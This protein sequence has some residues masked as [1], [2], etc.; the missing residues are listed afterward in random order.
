MFAGFYR[1]LGMRHFV[2]RTLPRNTVLLDDGLSTL[3]V[4]RVRRGDWSLTD[5]FP[6]S[7][8]RRLLKRVLN[9][10]DQE[11]PTVEYFTIYDLATEE[12]LRRHE[13]TSL[14]AE[15]GA[16]LGAELSPD[17]AA[18]PGTDRGRFR[19]SV[20]LGAPLVEDGYLSPAQY[21]RLLS[22]VFQSETSRN[23]APLVYCAHRR[24]SDARLEHIAELGFETERLELPI[25]L[26]VVER[27]IPNSI[28]SFYSSALP[29]LA[30]LLQGSV[31]LR[32]Y[33]LPSEM[34]T[35]VASARVDDCYQHFTEHFPSIEIVADPQLGAL[36]STYARAALDPS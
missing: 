3:S 19:G 12:S 1:S 10:G 20:F 32:A 35:E 30:V 5:H 34:L 2:A 17:L 21:D 26:E 36:N 11:F 4:P 14:R 22:I 6:E 31:P 24:E 29:N 28:G 16:E 23:P 15:L 13:F 8:F 25:E 7:R 33:R 18:P 27:G 9:V